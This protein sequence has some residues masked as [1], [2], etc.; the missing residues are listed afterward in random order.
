VCVC[1]CVCVCM[2]A[3]IHLA[4]LQAPPSHNPYPPLSLSPIHPPHPLQ[5]SLVTA[6]RDVLSKCLAEKLAV[7]NMSL[8]ANDGAVSENSLVF[9]RAF[10]MVCDLI[11]QIVN[12]CGTVFIAAA[13]ASLG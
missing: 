11:K 1:V 12:K 6:M 8:V 4:V 9:G 10:P 5:Y 2:S 3:A 13:G 7:V